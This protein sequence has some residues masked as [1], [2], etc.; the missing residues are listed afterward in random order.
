MTGS[1]TNRPVEEAR[2]GRSE[3][4]SLSHLAGMLVIMA[5]TASLWLLVFRLAKRGARRD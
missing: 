3:S 5:S 1:L 2:A 4:P